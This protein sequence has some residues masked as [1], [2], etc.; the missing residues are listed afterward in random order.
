MPKQCPDCGRVFPDFVDYCVADGLRLDKCIP[1]AYAQGTEDTEE[2]EP[3]RDFP[4][5]DEGEARAR[6]F[7]KVE[8][9]A[10]VFGVEF[11]SDV[12]LGRFDPEVGGV[13]V[14]LSAVPRHDSISPRH[15][16][17]VVDNHRWYVE[18]LGSKNG[19][20]INGGKAI[21]GRTP[22]SH[23]DELGLGAAL[24]TFEIIGPQAREPVGEAQS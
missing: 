14:D 22:L 4:V 23:G 16:R 2:I 10:E 12:V 19:V 3:T 8:G 17:L 13:D 11:A 5:I 24:F 1:G 7:P 6:L 15:A 21:E 9:E 18:D 20:F